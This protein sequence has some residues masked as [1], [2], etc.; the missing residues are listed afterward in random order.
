VTLGRGGPGLDADGNPE[1]SVEDRGRAIELNRAWDKVRAGQASAPART[2][3]VRYAEGSVE[4]RL[5]ARHGAA[6]GRQSRQGRYLDQGTGK[7]R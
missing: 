5:P 2:T 6:Q 1:P 7:A 4:T 3:L